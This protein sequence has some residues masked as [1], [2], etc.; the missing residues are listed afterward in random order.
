MARAADARHEP[1]IIY[2]LRDTNGDL[3]ADTKEILTTAYGRRLGSVEGNANSLY[4]AIDNRIHTTSANLYLVQKDDRFEIRQTLARGEWG[5]TQDDAGRL[6]RNS[7]EATLQVDLVP[8][9]YYARNPLLLRTRGS[10]EALRG[11]KDEVATVWPV[12][13]TPGTNRA[14]STGFAT[15]MAI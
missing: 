10:Y 1:G 13:P 2:W 7:S 8:T 5:L 15:R 3:K 4:W 6:Y 14:S 11:D 9:P 12:R